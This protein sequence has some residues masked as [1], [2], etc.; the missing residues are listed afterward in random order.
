MVMKKAQ[1]NIALRQKQWIKKRTATGYLARYS[2]NVINGF[3]L[4]M[5]GTAMM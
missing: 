3:G 4:E 2:S 1:K 5:T